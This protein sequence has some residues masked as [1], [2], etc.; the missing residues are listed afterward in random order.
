M[1]SLVRSISNCKK[2]QFLFFVKMKMSTNRGICSF[3]EYELFSSNTI[4]TNAKEV[5][6]IYLEKKGI[7]F[8]TNKLVL[9]T[10]KLLLVIEKEKKDY[11]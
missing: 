10:R 7:L 11:Y 8:L 4:Q 5:V 1:L 9:S 6:R 3:I 2:R